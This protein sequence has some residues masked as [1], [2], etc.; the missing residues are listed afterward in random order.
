MDISPLST[1]ELRSAKPKNALEEEEE[2]KKIITMKKKKKKEVEEKKNSIES[3]SLSL[4]LS[5]LLSL[6]SLWVVRY[7]GKEWASWQ[8]PKKEKMESAP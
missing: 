7:V 5:C 2:N 3:L 1:D 4:S 6:G 8:R